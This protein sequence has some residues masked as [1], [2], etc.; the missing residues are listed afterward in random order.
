[1]KTGDI[2]TDSR[3]AAWTVGPLLGEGVWGRTWQVKDDDQRVRVLKVP[4]EADD[5]PPAQAHRV[6][7]VRRCAEEAADRLAEGHEALIALEDRIV[8]PTGATA[9]LLPEAA[10]T[11]AR[12]IRSG[13]PLVEAL[14]EILAVTELLARTRLQHGNLHPGNI[15]LLPDGRAV[16]SDPL[17]PSLESLLPEAERSHPERRRWTAPDR[18]A[19]DTWALCAAL[20]TAAMLDEELVKEDGDLPPIPTDGIDKILRASLQDRASSRLRRDGAN[21]SFLLRTTERLAVLLDRGLSRQADPSPPYRFLTAKDL[22]PQLRELR[23]L[24]RPR[25]EKAGQILMSSDAHRGVFEAST[26]V[27]FSISVEA[28]PGIKDRDDLICGLHLVDLDAPEGEGRVPLP[29]AQYTVE[30][31]PS[32]RFRFAFALPALDP[33]R[34][35]IRVAFSIRGADAQPVLVEDRFEVRPPPGYVPPVP[36]EQAPTALPFSP[37]GGAADPPATA[38][39]AE[40]STRS[41]EPA[42]DAAERLTEPRTETD[43]TSGAEVVPIFPRPLAPSSYAEPEPEPEPPVSPPP[44]AAPAARRPTPLRAVP[45]PPP[46]EPEEEPTNPDAPTDPGASSRVALPPAP[47]TPTITVAAPP[48]I[49]PAVSTDPPSGFDEAPGAE[50]AFFA[51]EDDLPG[52]PG[53][54]QDLLPRAAPLLEQLQERFGDWARPD[55]P[56][57]FVVVVAGCFLLVAMVLALTTA[58]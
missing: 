36:E 54:G 19:N 9:L 44:I 47:P 25:I 14:D 8:L 12:Q 28:S 45:T 43:T 40:E 34:Y 20:Y 11:L 31:L 1:M 18:I 57:F 55:S 52:L 38:S 48:P 32:G 49:A 53:E 10:T 30:R 6:P 13:V 46:S 3:A 37:P 2:V 7:L 15:L 58:C 56:R 51:A 17:T 35:L 22:L 29:D 41:A 26:P 16:L 23:A 5:L 27:R 33:G 4:Y 50:G 39:P 21:P 24:V 42:T